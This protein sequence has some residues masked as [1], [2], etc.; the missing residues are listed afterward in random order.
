MEEPSEFS[1][2]L[3]RIR[4]VP[5]QRWRLLRNVIFAAQAFADST[6]KELTSLDKMVE[7]LRASPSRLDSSLS[8]SATLT[9]ISTHKLSSQL[10]ALIQR[11]S[12]EDL[13]VVQTIID[14]HP[15]RFTR[16]DGDPDYFLNKPNSFGV[17]PLYEAA[18]NGYSE[19]VQ[20]LLDNGADAKLT[21]KV[22]TRLEAPLTVASRWNH[23]EVVKTLLRNVEFTSK[24][25]AV[26]RKATHNPRIV[27]LL[28]G[29]TRSWFC[30]G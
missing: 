24:E 7:D 30:C 8:P 25:L 26:A 13:A 14:T 2:E 23:T 11:S 15:K 18:K 29:P 3:P 10:F 27:Q 20:L 12:P 9:E 1:Q 21:S 17:R 28:R 19:T 16:S 6:A 5:R 22:G 4:T